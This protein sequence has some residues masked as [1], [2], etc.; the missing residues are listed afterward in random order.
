MA[1]S[2]AQVAPETQ[3]VDPIQATKENIKAQEIKADNVCITFTFNP[4]LYFSNKIR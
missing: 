4:V 1:P 3:A 2:V